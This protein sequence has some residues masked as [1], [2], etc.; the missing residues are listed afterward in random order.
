MAHVVQASDG[1]MRI[2]SNQQQL[3]AANKWAGI[4][5]DIPKYCRYAIEMQV[6][7]AGQNPSNSG[8]G[9][10][11]GRL[12][13][14]SQPEGIAFQYDLGLN[15][16]RILTYPEDLQTPTAS[17]KL[18]SGWHQLLIIFS[19]SMTVYV[20]GR[21]VISQAVSQSCGVPIIRV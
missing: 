16:Y 3:T 20:D 11:S 21:S 5:A 19:G 7:I 10:A 15:G 17:A 6:S 12:N 13:A 1:V 9:I 8:Y 14:Q 4:V 2:T 18:D